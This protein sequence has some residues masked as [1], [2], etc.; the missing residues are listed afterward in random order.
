VRRPLLAVLAAVLLV[1]GIGAVPAAQ[2]EGPTPKRVASGWLPYWMT[3]PGRPDGVNSAVQNADL[4][5]DVSPFWYSATAKAGGGVQV[6]LNPNF[7]NGA[8]NAAWAMAQL[9]GAGLTVLPAIADGSGKGRMASTLA[10][11]A[12]RAQHVADIVALVVSNGYD[13]IDLD[14]EVFAFSDGSSSWGATQPN[15]T[16]F[17]TELGAALK[18]QGKLLAVTIPPPCNTAGSCGPRSGYWVYNIAG[19]APA[20]DRIRIMAYDYHVNGIGPIAPMPWV[21]SIVQYSVSIMDPAKLQIGV[22]TYGRAWTRLDGSKPRLSG[23][24]PTDKGSS[25]YRSLTA[26]ASVTDREIPALLASVGVTPADIQW[27]E[28]DQENWVYYDKKVNWTDAA[29]AT[30]TCTAKRVMWWVGP[31]AVLARTQLVGEFG[32]SAAAYWTIGGDDPAQ[33]PLIRSYAQS[34][35]PASTDVT[36]A[37]VPALVFGSPMAISSTV[38]SQGAPLAGVQALAQFRPAGGKKKAWTDVQSVATG[39]DGVAAFTVTPTQTGDWQV[40]VPP[41]D[42]RTEGVSAP[43]TTQ[44]LSLVTAV[45]KETRVPRGDRVVVKAWA[46]PAMPG[47]SV[48]LQIQRGAKWKNVASLKANDKGRARLVAS[49]PKVKGKYVYRVVAVAKGN[50][51]ANS[52]TEI[53]IRVTR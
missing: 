13:G 52:S 11:P 48:V 10:D 31:Q 2:A 33:W 41:A 42:A 51:L 14:Y 45:P 37:G 22:P 50:I 43:F 28:A 26:M 20:V 44:V 19:I 7:S 30:Q 21:R 25:A 4:F 32:L 12:L 39:P 17:V 38:T 6:R 36:A 27:S 8:A 35:A 16:A 49:V 3:T 1:T 47:Q 29:G 9:K 46:R 34:L 40:V 23:I 18:A 24:C 15:W 53:P 5:T